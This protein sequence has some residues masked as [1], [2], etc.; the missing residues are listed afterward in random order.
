[1]CRGPGRDPAQ[2]CVAGRKAKPPSSPRT[3]LVVSPAVC[4][5][6]EQIS[7]EGT[8]R[9]SCRVCFGC[10][11]CNYSCELGHGDQVALVEQWRAQRCEDEMEAQCY[12]GKAFCKAKWRDFDGRRDLPRAAA[13]WAASCCWSPV[14][15]LECCPFLR[16]CYRLM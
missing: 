13:C 2:I 7:F 1:M 3:L 10:L 6:A 4:G 16:W 5:L 12:A 9:R 14:Q 11:R 15:L 8:S